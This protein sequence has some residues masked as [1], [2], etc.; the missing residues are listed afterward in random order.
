MALG[1]SSPEIL[2]SVIEICG[3]NFMAGDLGPSTIV[4]SAAFNFLFI[5]GF[6]VVSIEAGGIRRIN[7]FKVFMTTAMYSV[8]AYIWL[9]IV[10]VVFTPNEITVWEAVI[11]F[12][13]FPLLVVNSYMVE[14]NCFIVSKTEKE[15]EAIQDMCKCE[16][17]FFFIFFCKFKCV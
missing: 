10:L 3:N 2:L 1:S 17:L 9:F 8:F 12:L 7:N 5:T 15:I 6:C 13:C 16:R 11:T 4:G 14:K